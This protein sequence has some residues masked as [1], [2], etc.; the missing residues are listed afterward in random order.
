MSDALGVRKESG[1]TGQR[2]TYCLSSFIF[3]TPFVAFTGDMDEGAC[4]VQTRGI[5]V[6]SSY[7]QRIIRFHATF[8]FILRRSVTDAELAAHSPVY[9]V[10][11]AF[12]RL[13]RKFVAEFD[14]DSSLSHSLRVDRP[15]SVLSRTFNIFQARHF[16][17]GHH[18]ILLNTRALREQDLRPQRVISRRLAVRIYSRPTTLHFIPTINS[19]QVHRIPTDLRLTR[20]RRISGNKVM[21]GFESEISAGD[22]REWQC[23]LNHRSDIHPSHLL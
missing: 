8:E 14:F 20:H 23:S 3:R 10:S 16:R 22:A 19:S 4:S 21:V 7:S 1:S 18:Q 17:S 6:Q 11:S 9:V 12:S 15:C 13:K 2:Y 5:S